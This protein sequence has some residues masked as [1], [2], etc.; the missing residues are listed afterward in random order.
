M[1]SLTL[2]VFSPT[3]FFN[4]SIQTHKCFSLLS[5]STLWIAELRALKDQDKNHAHPPLAPFIGQ[6]CLSISK[7]KLFPK[8]NSEKRGSP[9]SLLGQN[10]S[11]ELLYLYFMECLLMTKELADEKHE[12][13]FKATFDFPPWSTDKINKLSRYSNWKAINIAF[14]AIRIIFYRIQ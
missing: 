11:F 13:R 12:V 8:G 5:T 4:P 3:E 10:I 9:F 7:W 1:Y 2:S 14:S 6:F